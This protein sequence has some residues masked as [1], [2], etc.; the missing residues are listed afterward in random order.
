[1]SLQTTFLPSPVELVALRV[2]LTVAVRALAF[3]LPLAVA[4]AYGLTRRRFPGRLLLDL[5]SQA[6]LALPPVVVGFALLLLFG[7][8]GA[9]GATLARLGV[10]LAFTATG[11]SIASGVMAF[12]AMVRQLRL[13]FDAVDPRL[14]EAAASLGAPPWDR[15]LSVTLPLAGPG[16]IAAALTGFAMAMGEFG[17][18]ITFAADIPGETETLP[19][20]IYAALQTPGGEPEALRLSVMS[21]AVA[22]TALVAAEAVMRRLRRRIAP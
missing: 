21:L 4:V 18:V 15:L 22:G 3:S 13:A 14:D 8:H 12:P 5:I 9:L 17:A 2:S 19:L 7:A 16:M 1:M 20:A 10:R 6:P 11:A